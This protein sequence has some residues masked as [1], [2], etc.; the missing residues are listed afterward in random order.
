MPASPDLHTADP[1][2]SHRVQKW[3]LSRRALYDHITGYLLILPWLIGF[4]AWIATPMVISI[5]LSFTRY[6]LFSAPVWQGI[7]NYQELLKDDLI[8]K[9]LANTSYYAFIGVPLYT[10]TALAAALL[11]NQQVRGVSL[12][13]TI[14]YIPTIVPAV[15]GTLIW[16][17]IFNSD[18]GLANMFLRRLG[19]PPQRWFFDV[20]Q[21]KPLLIL[22][23]VWAFGPAMVLFLAALQNVP[24]ELVEA[25][26]IDG[27]G[28]RQR[29]F[30]IV[31]PMISPVTFFNLV[32]GFIGAFQV[33]V[34][35]YVATGGGPANATLFYVLYLYLVAFQYGK[36]GFAAAMAW[37]LFTIILAFTL[38]QL[39]VS[40]QW[41]Y[42]EVTPGT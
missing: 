1:G 10:A 20:Y 7:A 16:L 31:L 36:F 30:K 17:W 21:A 18:F 23:N 22:M 40:R 6:N 34:P 5:Y 33:F 14:Y 41:V 27:A 2:A 37:L 28:V 15:A 42:Y 19:L 26:L 11:L 38:V 12:F 9:S 32:T 35:A 39:Y 3:H 25:A 29:F 24:R 8:L 13:R 4:L